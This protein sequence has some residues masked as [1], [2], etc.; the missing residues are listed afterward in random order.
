MKKYFLFLLAALAFVAC[1]DDDDDV[2]SEQKP[3]QKVRGNT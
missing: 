2:A 3:G 1:G